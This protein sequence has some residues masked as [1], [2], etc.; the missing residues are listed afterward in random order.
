MI[1]FYFYL[2]N[3]S[4]FTIVYVIFKIPISTENV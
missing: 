1:L 3:L 2:F 4:L